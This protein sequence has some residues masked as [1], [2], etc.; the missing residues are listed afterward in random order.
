MRRLALVFALAL[1]L[2]FGGCTVTKY[3]PVETIKEVHV[4][5]SV[6]V[7]DT[8]VRVE[9][10]KARISDFVGL[11]DTLYLSDAYSRATA[12]VDTT[13]AILRGTI[14]TTKPYVEKPV[15]IKEK[16]TYRDSIV[17]QDRPVP[18]E[19]TKEVRYIPWW[20]KTLSW[21][22]GLTLIAGIIYILLKLGIF[23]IKKI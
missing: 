11:T 13:R 9:L 15:Q 22:G 12:F 18:Y 1:S 5:D 21:I 19:V 6:F 4:K 16:I 8:V 10:E 17:Y 2:A 20:A 23:S 14:E 3:I 7:K